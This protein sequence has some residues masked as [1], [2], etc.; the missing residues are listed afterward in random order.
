MKKKNLIISVFSFFFIVLVGCES[1]TEVTPKVLPETLFS[2]LTPEEEAD[3]IAYKNSDH[4]LFFGWINY[5]P[6]TPSMQTRL[7]GIPDSMDIVSFFTGYVDNEQNRR[8]VKFL[9]ERRGTKVLVTMWPEPYFSRGKPGANDLDSMKIYAKNLAESIF[10]WELDGFDLDYEPSF[11]GD[12]YSM[13]MMRTFIDV[14]SEYMGP[15]CKEEYKV[16]GKHKLLVVDGQW[17]D[18]EYADR[19]DYFIGQAYQS[20]SHSSLHS[21]L[22]GAGSRDYGKG[23]PNNK[24]IFCEWT[25]EVGNYFG[26]GGDRYNYFNEELGQNEIIPSLWGMAHYANEFN[27]AGCGVYV[28]QFAYA[29]DNHLSKPVPPNNYFYA[30]QAIQ[31][32]NPATI[33]KVPAPTEE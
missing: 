30:R 25:S 33:K 24:R 9:Q 20:S 18:P 1:W 8:D 14:M 4:K 26:G 13:E 19:F 10:E 6:A 27:T 15:K 5:S 3:L 28:L 11:G 29:E 16:N 12:S 2:S 32:M 21:R 7:I 22:D 31:I 23:F 17:Q